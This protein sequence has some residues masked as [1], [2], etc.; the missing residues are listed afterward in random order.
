MEEILLS[1]R[2]IAK[3]FGQGDVLHGIDLDVYKNEFLTLL[4]P[5]GCGKTTTLRIIAGLEAPDRG[6][7][8]LGG[9]D[10][11]A[12]APEKRSVNTVFQNYALFP[13]MNVA[14]NIGYGLR[15]RKVPK[16]EIKAQVKEMLSLV[17]L[18]GYGKRMPDQLSGG[19]RQ[20]VAIARALILR[21][22]LLLLDEPLG[23]LDLQLRRSMQLELKRLQKQSSITFIYIT[24]DQEEALNMSD[25]IAVMNDGRFEQIGT[26]DQI[27]EHPKTRFVAQFI[28]QTNL[29]DVRV[30]AI[31]PDGMVT[32][33]HGEQQ[34]MVRTGH[35]PA[36]EAE[37]TLSV[38]A[39]RL[40]FGP[41]KQSDFSLTGTV[42]ENRYIGGA[43]TSRITLA[44]GQELIANSRGSLKD[45][46]KEGSKVYLW[47]DP[48]QVSLVG[49]ADE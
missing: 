27:Y 18:E 42:T 11:T 36:V 17:Q 9:E 25:R 41:E 12:L 49:E 23:A 2:G 34:V 43:L 5:S 20:R 1:L 46:P 6:T 19:Q 35:P 14:N 8:V 26:P 21:P 22:Q 3:H 4:G 32:L 44:D 45:A 38:R 48:V 30:A 39:E 31:A 37:V 47:W 28:G 10:V 33:C 24:H 13:H 40:S 7:V 16:A 15:L 29:I